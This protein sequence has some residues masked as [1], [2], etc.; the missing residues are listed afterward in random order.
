MAHLFDSG[1][2][3]MSDGL[4]SMY[5]ILGQAQVTNSFVIVE[6]WLQRVAPAPN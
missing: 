6:A 5:Q 4:T 2:T 3:F 1:T